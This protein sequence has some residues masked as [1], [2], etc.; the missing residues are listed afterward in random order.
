MPCALCTSSNQ[1]EFTAEINIHLGGLKNID[2]PG[3]LAFPRLLVCL[4]CGF[5]Q[6]TAP[7]AELALL[8]GAVPN[9]K[10]SNRAEC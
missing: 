8:A 5:T 1:A 4:D 7:E 2:H 6:F 3:V 10:T 9:S